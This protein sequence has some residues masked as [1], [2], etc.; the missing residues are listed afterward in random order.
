VVGFRD[1]RL[2][3]AAPRNAA[4]VVGIDDAREMTDKLRQ[5]MT[6][7]LE[8]GSS[9]PERVM[10]EAAVAPPILNRSPSELR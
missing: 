4:H 6:V 2:F 5:M 10:N 3:V 1:P 9:L 7:V 8:E